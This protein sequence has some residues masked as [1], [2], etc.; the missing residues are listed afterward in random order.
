MTRLRRALWLQ[1][2]ACTLVAVSS[3]AAWAQTSAEEAN[4]S[5]NPLNPSPGLNFQNYYASKLYDTDAHTN[6]FLLRGTLPIAP[7]KMIACRRRSRRAIR[8]TR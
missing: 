7:G 2:I 5:N 6:D 3:V 8:S 1:S 4:K